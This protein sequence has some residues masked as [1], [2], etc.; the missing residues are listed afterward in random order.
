MEN[1]YLG[2]THNAILRRLALELPLEAYNWRMRV[3]AANEVAEHENAITRIQEVLEMR[4][5]AF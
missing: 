1:E 2:W 4:E 3:V 5:A